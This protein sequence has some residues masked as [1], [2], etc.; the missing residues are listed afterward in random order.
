MYF[1]GLHV[2]ERVK[3]LCVM[4]NGFRYVSEFLGEGVALWLSCCCGTGKRE[5]GIVEKTEG[6]LVWPQSGEG[7]QRDRKKEWVRQK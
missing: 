3:D 1:S 2:N 6:Q 5:G 7:P 4:L